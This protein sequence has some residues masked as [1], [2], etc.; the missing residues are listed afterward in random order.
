MLAALHANPDYA[1]ILTWGE[2]MSQLKKQCQN[3]QRKSKQTSPSGSGLK[4]EKAHAAGYGLGTAILGATAEC[5]SESTERGG[6]SEAI[7]SLG[8]L[9]TAQ[10][11]QDSKYCTDATTRRASIPSTCFSEPTLT[12]SATESGKGTNGEPVFLVPSQCPITRYTV[13][14]KKVPTAEASACDIKPATVSPSPYSLTILYGEVSNRW[15][16][17]VLVRLSEAEFKEPCAHLRDDYRIAWLT[18][19]HCSEGVEQPWEFAVWRYLGISHQKYM[20]IQSERERYH[21]SLEIP[22]YDPTR[23]S[24]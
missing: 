22:D 16:E 13:A 7:V 12:I 5:A 3:L 9:P 21:R 24:A 8:N 23:R 20:K 19:L 10:S 17:R 6:L 14:E 15:S 11:P 4:S 18:V 1:G 2:F